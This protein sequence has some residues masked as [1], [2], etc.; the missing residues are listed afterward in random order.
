[1]KNELKVGIV[2]ADSDEY[3]P[4]KDKIDELGAGQANFYTREGLSFEFKQDGK[5]VKAHIVNC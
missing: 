2:I 4:I 3:L 1:M 5:T